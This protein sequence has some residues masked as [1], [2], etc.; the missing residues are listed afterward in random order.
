MLRPEIGRTWQKIVYQKTLGI[1]C[2]YFI[3]VMGS[4]G[5]RELY[6]ALGV[7]QKF[8]TFALEKGPLVKAN[9]TIFGNEIALGEFLLFLHIQ[10]SL[11]F[12][13]ATKLHSIS[14]T[15]IAGDTLS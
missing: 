14:K 9:F 1:Y 5:Y 2:N 4:Y 12:A 11:V 15:S 3:P 8:D 13:Y 6:V 10:T 7:Q